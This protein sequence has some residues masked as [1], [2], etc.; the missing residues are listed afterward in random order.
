[1]DSGL[2][3]RKI[4]SMA[5]TF[6]GS[7]AGAGAGLL[8]DGGF[9]CA[10][11]EGERLNRQQSSNLAES[12]CN[13]IRTFSLTLRTAEAVGFSFL[14]GQPSR[15]DFAY[16]VPGIVIDPMSRSSNVDY[17]RRRAWLPGTQQADPGPDIPGRVAVSVFVFVAMW[18]KSPPTPLK[19]IFAREKPF[20]GSSP[21]AFRLFSVSGCDAG[22]D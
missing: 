1:M 19:N 8:V 14:L 13:F 17:G 7:T 4:S 10:K 20:H 9:D 11:R 2:V 18:T 15:V 22:N 3:I 12:C 5:A 6:F 21:W 16:R